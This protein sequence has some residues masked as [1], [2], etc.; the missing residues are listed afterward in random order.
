[1]NGLAPEYH[2]YLIFNMQGHLSRLL[3]PLTMLGVT[4]TA[5][6]GCAAPL[7]AASNLPSAQYQLVWNDEFDGTTLDDKKWGLRQPGQR[8]GGFNTADNAKLDGQGNLVIT[9]KRESPDKITTA[10]LSTD[11]KYSARYGYYECRVKLQKKPGNWSAFWLQSPTVA[12][13]GDTRKNGAEVDIYEYAIPMGSQTMSNLHWYGY[14]KDH[15]TAGK[16]YDVENLNDGYHVFG[17]EWTPDSYRFYT[18]GKLM[19]ETTASPSNRDQYIIL[20]AE[21]PLQNKKHWSG[22]SDQFQDTDE[23]TFDYVRV[24][25]TPEQKALNTTLTA[26]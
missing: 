23:V 14:G 25:Q 7:T 10:M 6:A 19:W 17:C 24:Y 13:V 5:G 2:V 15:Q 1:M 20:S 4:L 18:D 11:G 21:V 16:H 26:Q 9:V 22:Q 12:T 8:V 3:F